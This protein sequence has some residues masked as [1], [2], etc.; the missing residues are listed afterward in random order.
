MMLD[1]AG[2]AL[3]RKGVVCGGVALWLGGG[4]NMLR[5]DALMGAEAGPGGAGEGL[6]IVERMGS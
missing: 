4:L 5:D 1:M 6:P 3:A 2:D